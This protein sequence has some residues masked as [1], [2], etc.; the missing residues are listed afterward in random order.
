VFEDKKYTRRCALWE[1][2]AAGQL[3]LCTRR[4]N[5]SQP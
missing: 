2:K 1:E 5:L 3:P 4:K